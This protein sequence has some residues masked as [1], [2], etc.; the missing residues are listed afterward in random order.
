MYTIQCVRADVLGELVGGEGDAAPQFHWLL[1]G[2]D[3]VV[4]ECLQRVGQTV[5]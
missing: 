1:R 3:L 2:V 4:P 5:G